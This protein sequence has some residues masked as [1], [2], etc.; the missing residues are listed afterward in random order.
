MPTGRRTSSVVVAVTLALIGLYV[1][2]PSDAVRAAIWMFAG[3]SATAAILIAV[4]RGAPRGPPPVVAARRRHRAGHQ[5]SGRRADRRR[6]VVRRRPAPARLP[7][8]AGA[9]IA[10]QRD[11]IR[12]DRASLLDALVV[13][14]AAAQAGWLV[15]DR[16]AV[17]DDR[18]ATCCSSPVAGA[19]PL[20][21]LLVLGVA[22]PA[23][24][25][26]SSAAATSPPAW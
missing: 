18:H 14:V 21:D 20:G 8:M 13:T 23:R 2:V 1:A 9:V 5:R 22:D 7:A 24:R 4:R 16:A 6:R 10:F 19:Y 17:R 12:H 15:A 26:P 25:S 3:V 11:R